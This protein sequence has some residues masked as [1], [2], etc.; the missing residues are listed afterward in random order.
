MPKI[1]FAQW[2]EEVKK[3]WPSGTLCTLA[4]LA[5]VPGREPVP[6]FKVVDIMEIHW[7]AP[8]GEVHQQPRCVHVVSERYAS[9][10]ISYEPKTLRKLTD[11][12]I[13]H[14]DARNK[15]TQR[16]VEGR[17]FDDSANDTFCG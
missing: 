6:V 14:V 13:K 1:E 2:I 3:E 10:H 17:S 5:Y 7:N 15:A 11:E 12:E 16:S 8:I 9:S 4:S